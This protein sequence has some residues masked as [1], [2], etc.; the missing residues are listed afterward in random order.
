MQP[1]KTSS[2]RLPPWIRLRLASGGRYIALR[3]A[4]NAAA[5]HTVCESA[6]CPN[7]PECFNR[8][9]ATFMILGNICTRHCR[10]CAVAAGRPL[11]LDPDESRRIAALT[12]QLGL[13]H[14]VVTS[15]TRDDLPDGGAGQFAAT[16]NQ[17]KTVPGLTIE[18]LT[19][20]FQGRAQA[21]NQ[22][23]L[24]GPQVFNHNLETVAR[25]QPLIRPQ[26]NYRRSLEVLSL[27]SQARP[28]PIVKSG[29]MVG[30][31]ETDAELFRAFE[32]LRS[33]GCD[34]LTIGQYLA[35]S[36]RHIPV[37]RFVAPAHF[38]AYRAKA[39]SLGFRAVAAGPL[40]RSSYHAEE[41]FQDCN[42]KQNSAANLRGQRSLS[43]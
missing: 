8:G 19:P 5:L 25:L 18:I 35:P 11:A 30:L 16:I 2:G 27:A 12:K 15:V 17:L 33:A 37:S 39:L 26:A 21:I 28:R 9:T 36:L 34:L 32:D 10:F 13:S 31:G 43:A 40:V 38:E 24:A 29:L 4:L 20:D 3:Q 42:P 41:L 23:L 7:R 14:V 6:Q 22:V 1:A